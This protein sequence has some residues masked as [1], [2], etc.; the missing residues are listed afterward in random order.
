MNR[1][2]LHLS[3]TIIYEYQNHGITRHTV[4]DHFIRNKEV[5]FCTFCSTLCFALPA[6]VA[7]GLFYTGGFLGKRK[8]RADPWF[9]IQT[10]ISNSF[11]AVTA[12]LVK[13]PP[14]THWRSTAS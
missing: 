3:V 2:A 6:H 5:L 10:G 14:I 7:Q 1:L 4:V 8:Q 11:R 12:R 13:D 9:V